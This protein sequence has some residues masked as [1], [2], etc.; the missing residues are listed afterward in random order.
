MAGRTLASTLRRR[1]PLD[2]FTFAPASVGL[3][4][5]AED[6][7]AGRLDAIIG[8]P[9]NAEIRVAV[10]T[11]KM[12]FGFYVRAADLAPL[13]FADWRK[14]GDQTPVEWTPVDWPIHGAAA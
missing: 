11:P 14:K 6:V 5:L 13:L 10:D 9:I 12:F 2:P 7:S 1:R 8:Q 3:A 4:Q